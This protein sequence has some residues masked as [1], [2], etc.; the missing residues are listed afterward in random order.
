M[1]PRAIH[2]SPLRPPEI[3]FCRGRRSRTTVLRYRRLQTRL[4]SGAHTGA[5]YDNDK[6][7]RK[8]KP[9]E[10][11]CVFVGFRHCLRLSFCVNPLTRVSFRFYTTLSTHYRLKKYRYNCDIS[12]RYRFRAVVLCPPTSTQRIFSTDVCFFRICKLL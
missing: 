12:K 2:E 4:T 5:P 1:R 8:P 9:S 3:T 11:P 7:P 6:N 10:V